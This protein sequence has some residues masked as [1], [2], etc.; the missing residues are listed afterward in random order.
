MTS[1]ISGPVSDAPATIGRV[2][3]RTPDDDRLSAVA[4]Q[5]ITDLAT[6]SD[7]AF[8]AALER[9]TK[10]QQ[11]VG[12]I[13]ERVL[14]SGAHFG[15]PQ[16]DG[17]AV[18]PKPIL[19]QSGAEVLE[20]TFR[21]AIYAVEPDR[22]TIIEP[23]TLGPKGEITDPGFVSVTVHRVLHALDGTRIGITSANC[24]SRE[25][26]F[27]RFGSGGR[28]TYDDARET[29]NDCIAMAEKRAKVRLIR[30]AL[31]LTAWL[32]SEEEMEAATKEPEEKPKEQEDR[33]IEPWTP[34]EQEQCYAAAQAKGIK[35]K[36]F[37]ALVKETLGTSRIG[38]G[39]DVVKVLAAIEAWQPPAKAEAPAAPESAAAAPSEEPSTSPAATAPDDESDESEEEM[40]RQ[41]LELVAEEERADATRQHVA[42]SEAPAR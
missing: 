39:P 20:N 8:E 6:M 21:L 28:W 11:R 3:T 23:A 38:S 4:R 30:G 24:N 7:D 13:L 5:P 26:R 16:K 14:I 27:R 34:E 31:G 1:P 33:P 36:A 10:A 40:R 35:R 32:A 9:A 25:K 29:L 17:K 42:R 12:K 2:V 15:N 41:E 37:T 19:F 18:F 22:E